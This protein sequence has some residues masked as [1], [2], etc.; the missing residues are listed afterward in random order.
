MTDYADALRSL[1]TA[2]IDSRNGYETALENADGKGLGPL[3]QDMIAMREAHA[4]ELAGFVTAAG[5]TPD[6]DGS[7]MSSVH[8]AVIN[9]R[10]LLTGLNESILPG[11]IDGE[12]RIVSSYDEAIAA[13]ASGSEVHRKLVA[14]RDGVRAKIATIQQRAAAAKAA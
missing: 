13:A 5:E 12:E 1:H 11:L 6:E 3:F 2:L 7:I 14:Q 4:H 8:K 9:V 10:A